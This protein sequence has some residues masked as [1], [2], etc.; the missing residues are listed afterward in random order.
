M[1]GRVLRIELL[2][3]VAPWTAA[4]A[5]LVGPA[6]LLLTGY[7]TAQWT[8]VGSGP[9]AIL[10][11]LCPIALGAGAWQGRREHRTKMDE[12]LATTP[13][14]GWQRVLPPSAALAIALLLGYLAVLVIAVVGVVGNASYQHLG[15]VPT[16]LV[17]MIA[18]LAAGLLGQGI[19]RLVPSV[20][21]A[22]VLVIGSLTGLA[23][24]RGVF[25]LADDVTGWSFAEATKLL[26]PN[27]PRPYDHFVTVAGLVNLGQAIW[28]VAL[29]A[30]GFA[31]TFAA[32]R[33]ARWRAVL[34]TV[35]SLVVVLPIMPQGEAAVFSHDAA[36]TEQV[37][38]PDLPRV[39]VTR[40]HAAALADLTAPGREALKLLATLPDP[41]T[42]VAED[43]HDPYSNSQAPVKP[44]PP[45]V[46]LIHLAISDLD[47][48]SRVTVGK[49]ELLAQFLEGAGTTGCARIHN[50]PTQ[51]E[52]QAYR[53]ENLARALAAQLLSPTPPRVE[54]GYA[55]DENYQQAWQ[56]V[57]ALPREEQRRRVGALRTAA[58]SC[59]G[60][61]MTILTTGGTR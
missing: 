34:P 44:Q 27:V 56:V 41:P 4:L 5:L 18:L 16:V 14:P 35:L 38:T 36:A 50:N 45:G 39:C 13:R 25:E 40:V 23:A 46:L 52:L 53:R 37:C 9:Q 6:A 20:L 29:A 2:R 55:G 43:W 51:Q 59:H 12:L 48:R 54:P 21:T 3:S 11:Y 31:W 57:K 24:A 60:D 17:G 1:N 10:E 26:V 22:P 30:T 47:A 8:S 61:L 7:E 15:W 58:L 28:F 42:S 19:G 49:E 33:R 32:T